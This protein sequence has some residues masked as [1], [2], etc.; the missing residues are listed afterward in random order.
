[1]T[2]TTCIKHSPRQQLVILRE[3]YVDLCEGRHCAAALLNVFEHWTNIKLG[4]REQAQTENAIAA[5]EGKPLVDDSLWIFKSIAELKAELLG[6]W[7]DRKIADDL[8]YLTESRGFLSKRV[9]P[10]YQY[11]KT[12]QYQLCIERLQAALNGENLPA[13]IGENADAKPDLETAKT[14]MRRNRKNAGSILQKRSIEAAKMRHRSRKKAEAIPEITTETTPETTSGDKKKRADR[15]PS[16][17]H[18]PVN[19]KNFTAKHIEAFYAQ[20]KAGVESLCLA[21]GIQVDTVPFLNQTRAEQRIMIDVFR[22]LDEVGVKAD[23][24]AELVAF[25]RREWKDAPP[26][27]LTRKVSAWRMSKKPASYTSG[28]FGEFVQS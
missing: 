16:P 3:D 8:D 20:Y 4:Q 24:F 7:A 22:Q 15:A 6:L 11:D 17:I 19:T 23:D 12:R 10:K 26:S 18:Y 1:M 2:K 27:Q 14:Q 13:G 21:W 25:V 28:K 5:A 9:N